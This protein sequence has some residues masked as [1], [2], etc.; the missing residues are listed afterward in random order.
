MGEGDKMKKKSKKIAEKDIKPKLPLKH[1]SI[2][3]FS[4]SNGLLVESKFLPV[5]KRMMQPPLLSK[6]RLI[7]PAVV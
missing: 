3:N 1:R 6:P 5:F 4:R 7:E 2:E